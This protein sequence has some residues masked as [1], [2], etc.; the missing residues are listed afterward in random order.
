MQLLPIGHVFQDK[1]TG[2]WLRVIAHVPDK[3][4]R[5]VEKV[6][7]CDPPKP[8]KP[9]MA[10]VVREPKPKVERT[11]FKWPKRIAVKTTM[12]TVKPVRRAAAPKPTRK[13][14]K[15]STFT[16]RGATALATLVGTG[17]LAAC[18]W[19]LT[20]TGLMLAGCYGIGKATHR[21]RSPRNGKQ[22]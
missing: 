11:P 12:A 18:G 15:P 13:A 1:T 14:K 22:K 8:E 9:I 16:W 5:V 4:G 6:E 20:A 7:P 2:L 17:T 19:P 3:Y 21:R 10:K